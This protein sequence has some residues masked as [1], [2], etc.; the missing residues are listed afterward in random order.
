VYIAYTSTIVPPNPEDPQVSRIHRIARVTANGNVAV[1]GSEVIL[2]DGIRSDVDSH[3]GGGLRFGP[4]GFLYATT[5]DGAPYS[6]PNDL[7][8]RSQNIDELQGKVLRI[9]RNGVPPVTNPYYTTPGAVRSKVWQRGL[10]NP[11]KM[12]LRPGTSKLYINDVGSDEFEE[13]NTAG[14]GANFGWPCFE[15]PDPHPEYDGDP[16]CTGVVQTPPVHS[17]E[18]FS[19]F[20]AAITGG[21][22]YDGGNYPPLYSDKLFIGDYALHFIKYLTITATDEV[23]AVTDFATGDDVFLPVDLAVGP[24]GNLYY[25][26]IATDLSSPTGSINRIVY[27]GAGNHAP[28]PV[29]SAAPAYGYAPL[30]VQFSSAGTTDPDNNPLT[31]HWIFGDGAEADGASVSHTYL[32]NGVFTATLRVNDG[33]LTRD[34][35]VI[36]TVGS[37]P[38][39]A[40][41]AT[42]APNVTF[43][44]GEVIP[45]SGSASDVDDGLLPATS[46]RWTVLQHHNEHEHPYQDTLG[47]SGSFLAAGHGASGDPIY[48]ELVLTATDSS[49]LE[50]TRRRNILENHAP[51]ANAGLDQNV[52]CVLPTPVVRL[53]GQ[54]SFD[55]DVQPITYAWTQ[56]SGTPVTLQGAN[57]AVATFAPPVFGSPSTLG[58][59]LDVRDAHLSLASDTIVV[60]VPALTD[61]DGDGYPLCGD[62]A[63]GNPASPPAMTSQLSFAADKTTIQWVSMPGATTYELLRGTLSGLASYDHACLQTG[64]PGPAGLDASLPSALQKGFYY[65]S[66]GRDGC[67]VGSVGTS[68]SGLPRPNP[69]C[70]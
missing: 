21:A 6:V 27:V 47:A 59:R 64:L 5:G 60:N 29:A 50:H 33:A 62:C 24:D 3:T 4:D 2:V 1:A 18:N 12:T 70:P 37:M 41:I 34:D 46:L 26:N 25:L 10:R 42:P 45:F 69:A 43:V 65:L 22:F 7:R 14:P 20:G 30:A 61:T 13:V 53:D 31:Y 17:Y 9:D 35:R 49:G 11:F 36:V 54:N 52:A 58:F 8:F 23:T 44:N 39:V 19:A 48:Y 32:A 67:G 63:P 38:P 16:R 55:P 66:R 15:G 56:I 51:A 40:T 68:S 28:K 57:T